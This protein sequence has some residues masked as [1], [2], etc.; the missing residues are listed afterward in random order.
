MLIPPNRKGNDM[1][2]Q[3]N[4]KMLPGFAALLTISLALSSCSLFGTPVPGVPEVGASGADV[5]LD[6]V[7]IVVPQGAAPTGTKVNAS[8]QDQEP[9]GV[10]GT[11][12]KTLAK[13]FKITLGDGLQPVEP[14][15]VT[16]PVDKGLLIGEQSSDVP[17]TVAMMIQSEGASE[18]DLV[19]ATWDPAAGTVTAKVP[20]LS[21]VWPVQ[22]DLGAIMKKVM[23]TT[24]LGMGIEYPKP[25]CADKPATIGATTYTAISPAQAWICVEESAGS[26]IVTASPNSPIPTMATATPSSVAANRTEVSI[27]NAFSV[28]LG[29]SLGFTSGTRAIM[30]PGADAQFTVPGTPEEVRIHFSHYPIMQLASIL[31]RTLE[32]SLELFASVP[33]DAIAAAGCMQ[34]VFNT[35]QVGK[36]LSP[37]MAGGII[38]SFFACAGTVL[39]LPFKAQVV[40][41]ILAS[42]PQ[43]II[44]SML[45]GAIRVTSGSEY[46]AVITSTR[47]EASKPALKTYMDPVMGIR[48]DYPAEWSTTEPTPVLNTEGP[49]VFENGRR[50]ATAVLGNTFDLSPC[51]AEN[52]YQL[53]ESTPVDIPGMDTSQAPTTIKTEVVDY[54]SGPAASLDGKSVRL[55]VQLYSNPGHP[56]GTTKVCSTNGII[57]HEGKYG[58]FTSD[59]GFDTVQQAKEYLTSPEYRK[60]K[61]MIASLRFL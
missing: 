12:L 61:A 38:K 10:E 9:A 23:D 50:L 35:S 32:V 16:I 24:L 20:H 29:K 43:F 27:G 13:A 60:I 58:F 18:P 22:L 19:P 11:H 30:M 31:A 49:V 54:S 34:N 15:T 41:A 14:L 6:G 42:G 17:L 7:R 44:T 40:L 4:L 1:R 51:P 2:K 33:L 36:S 5:T 48:F 21:W 46:T 37:E 59:L 3:R 28:A 39:D 53:L 56:A 45:G 47:A 8:F 52:P 26:L 55:Y 57:L 25:A